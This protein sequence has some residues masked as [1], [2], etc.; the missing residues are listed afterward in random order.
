MSGGAASPKAMS[1]VSDPVTAPDSLLAG[2]G[3][4]GTTRRALDLLIV[5]RGSDRAA[6]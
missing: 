1:L 6:P 3:V 5:E 4:A 2:S